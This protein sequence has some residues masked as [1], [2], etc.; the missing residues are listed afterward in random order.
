MLSV[1]GQRGRPSP[2]IRLER[3]NV[4]GSRPARR[5]RAEGERPCRAAM[6]SM[7]VQ[8]QSWVNVVAGCNEAS[9]RPPRVLG[10]APSRRRTRTLEA[11]VA[12]WD[13]RSGRTLGRLI[14][15]RF[16]YK[17]ASLAEWEAAC[18]I[19]H[20]SGSADDRRDGYIHLSTADQLGSTLAKHF[21]GQTGLALIEIRIR[22]IGPSLR[23]EASRSG[24][25]YPHLYADLPTAAAER[26]LLLQLDRDGRHVIPEGL[27]GC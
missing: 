20:F 5:A 6:V 8:I 27:D 10:T 13:I 24:S 4:V 11:A 3:L 7:A 12:A 1:L 23:W 15:K 18:R 9:T 22:P 14:M 16:V 25:V 17:V 21:A 2:V 26:V 19:G